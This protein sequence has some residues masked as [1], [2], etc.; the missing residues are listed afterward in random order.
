MIGNV[1]PATNIILRFSRR[2]IQYTLSYVNMKSI[3]IFLNTLDIDFIYLLSLSLYRFPP[4]KFV[5]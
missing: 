4:F 1:V 2:Q 3:A 5:K